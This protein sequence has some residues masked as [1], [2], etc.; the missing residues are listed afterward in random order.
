[1]TGN[2]SSFIK[3]TEG[4]D[5]QVNLRGGN[6]Q[7]VKGKRVIAVQTR[8]VENKYIFDVLYVL[9]LTQNLLSVG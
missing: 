7:K 1:M 3:L 2:K 5:S 4:G 8:G 9:R 6:L